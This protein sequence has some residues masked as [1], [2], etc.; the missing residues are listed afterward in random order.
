MQHALVV[1]AAVVGQGQADARA[2]G[3]RGLRGILEHLLRQAMYELPA[4]TGVKR[5]VVNEAVAR[6][7]SALVCIEARSPV[8][9]SGGVGL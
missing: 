8:K 4:L 9:E 5:V 7:D 1:S 3:A 2:T 6:G